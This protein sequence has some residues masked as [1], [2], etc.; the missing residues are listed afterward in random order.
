MWLAMVA[1]VLA[2]GGVMFW[3]FYNAH[4]RRRRRREAREASRDRIER[5][6]AWDK[7]HHVRRRP[8]SRDPE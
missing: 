7:A 6:R 8:S 1:V 4:Q 2:G 5:A 3:S